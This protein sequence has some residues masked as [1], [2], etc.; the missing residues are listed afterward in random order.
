M[1]A[2][3]S[4]ALTK[5]LRWDICKSKVRI[6]VSLNLFKQVCASDQSGLHFAAQVAGP[7]FAVLNI[8]NIV[9]TPDGRLYIYI[10]LFIY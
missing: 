8:L 10:Y 1:F 9:A 2:S 4:F 6:H 7:T 3:V 5:S